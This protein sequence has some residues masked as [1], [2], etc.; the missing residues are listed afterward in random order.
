MFRTILLVLTIPSILASCMSC[1]GTNTTRTATS[2]AISIQRLDPRDPVS[3]LAV[4]DDSG[5]VH[6]TVEFKVVHVTPGPTYFAVLASKA[7]EILGAEAIAWQAADLTGPANYET[8][9]SRIEA[10]NKKQ[11][12]T[13]VFNLGYNRGGINTMVDAVN[14]YYVKLNSNATLTQDVSPQNYQAICGKYID[15]SMLTLEEYEGLV[16]DN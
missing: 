14:E 1:G 16:P 10:I 2:V 4:K 13:V 5:N 7:G 9:A 15:I 8:D 12:K 6:L 3:N 11:T